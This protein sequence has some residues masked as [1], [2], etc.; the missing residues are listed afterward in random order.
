MYIERLKFQIE[1]LK[2]LDIETIT[3]PIERV[4]YLIDER[5]EAVTKLFCAELEI[6]LLKEGKAVLYNLLEENCVLRAKLA[7]MES[8]EP[9]GL[10]K[11]VGGYPDES[12]HTIKWLVKHRHITDGQHL[13]AKP[14]PADKPAV[15]LPKNFQDAIVVLK[16]NLRDKD[17]GVKACGIRDNDRVRDALN[18]LLSGI[19]HNQQSVEE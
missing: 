17:R 2:N 14:I 19:S 16:E 5:E 18:T 6:S 1:R 3:L 8:Q 15:A 7:E 9:I 12:E 11:T 10:V 13:Y 4:E